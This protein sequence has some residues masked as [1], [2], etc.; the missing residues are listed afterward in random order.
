MINIKP[1]QVFTNYG[2]KLAVKFNLNSIDD[3][4][5]SF[6]KFQYF[7]CDE[8]GASLYSGNLTMN[9]PDYSLWNSGTNINQDAYVWA[10]TELG[11]TIIP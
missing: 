5:Q 4:L 11:L 6:C 1:V 10:T 2:P 3:D 7:L 8:N 9:E